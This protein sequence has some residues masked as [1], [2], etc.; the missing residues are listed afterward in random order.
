MSPEFAK[1]FADDWVKAWNSHDVTQILSHYTDDFEMHSPVIAH[2]TGQTQGVLKGKSAVGAY[3]ARALV[4]MPDLH[5]ELIDV[6]TSVDA[7]SIHYRGARNKRVVEVL[8][9][10]ADGLVCCAQAFY[11]V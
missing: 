11:E 10:N 8:H 5:F 9:F 1:Q 2:L 7:M 6:F 3:W 4:L